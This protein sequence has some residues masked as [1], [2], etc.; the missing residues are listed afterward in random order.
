MDW[1]YLQ[2]SIAT[3]RPLN[4]FERQ[5]SGQLIRVDMLGGL[6][7]TEYFPCGRTPLCC[8]L[9]DAAKRH[10]DASASEYTF[11]RSSSSRQTECGNSDTSDRQL[12]ETITKYYLQL[13][14]V[15][16][17]RSAPLVAPKPCA[18]AMIALAS[19]QL[20]FKAAD[21]T[22]PGALRFAALLHWA[23]F[24]ASVQREKLA[25]A[26]ENITGA[27]GGDTGV[28]GLSRSRR[29]RRGLLVDPW[30]VLLVSTGGACSTVGADVGPL[31][32][33]VG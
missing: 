16:P 30:Q 27:S 21:F 3:Q 15:R 28:A 4:S 11:M 8:D 20:P 14:P 24:A 7:F 6:T 25:A 2:L 10:R 33:L 19:A 32:A 26:P 22:A 29:R 13:D 18:A 17:E 31:G 1:S 9:G 23:F 12:P 5:N